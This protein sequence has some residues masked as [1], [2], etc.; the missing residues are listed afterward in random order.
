MAK[1]AEHTSVGADRSR[2]E[3]EKT[4]QRYGATGFAYGWDQ[5][6]ALIT[7]QMNERRI[8]FVLTMP[9]RN[10]AEFQQ[11]PSGRSRKQPQIYEAWEQATRQRWRALALAVKAKL[12][13]VEA[14]I[15]T[16][17][18]EFLAHIVLADDTTVAERAIPAIAKIYESGTMLPL[19]PE[20]KQL[21]GG[22]Q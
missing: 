7:F 5:S 21:T 17:D 15:T 12:E 18:E 10:A 16:F 6:R 9:D 1:F 20:M 19:I 11:T 8:R 4:V 13:A 2:A 3:I 22:G 14:G